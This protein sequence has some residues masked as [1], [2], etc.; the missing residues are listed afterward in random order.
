MSGSQRCES[1]TFSFRRKTSGAHNS[2]TPLTH[3]LLL[4]PPH[5]LYCHSNIWENRMGATFDLQFVTDDYPFA[6]FLYS[7]RIYA[8]L[9]KNNPVSGLESASKVRDEQKASI[10][11]RI[12]N[13]CS[14]IKRATTSRVSDSIIKVS[15][16]IFSLI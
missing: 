13:P 9:W 16:L 3:A 15:L 5:P 1:L 8:G 2:C 11:S 7:S 6:S 12:D 4:Y 10:A 14:S